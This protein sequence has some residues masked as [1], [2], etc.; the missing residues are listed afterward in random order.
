MVYDCVIIGGGI[1]GLQCAIQLGRYMYKVL[2][3]DSGD[4]RSTLCRSYHNVL[5]YPSGVSGE[6]LRSIGE[7]QAK[8]Y[9]VEFLLEKVEKV[10]KK[11]EVFHVTTHHGDE[12]RAKRLLLATGV[13]DRIPPI[14][15]LYP[16]LG[17]SVYICPDCDG[18]EIKDQE[19]IV[20]GSGNVGAN[21]ALTLL[22]W[23][24]KLVY[25]NHERKEVDETLLKRLKKENIEYY[26]ESIEQVQAKDG[27]FQGVQLADGTQLVSNHGFVAFGNNEVRSELAAQLGV[28]RMENK[29]ILVDPRSKMTNIKHVWAAGD[30]VAHSEQVTV[31]MGDGLQAAIFIHKSLMNE[32]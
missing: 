25:V 1:A 21:A 11:N 2:V 15:E 29:H 17:Q 5:G 30:V 27:Q 12:K 9:G 19:C 32:S 20:I 22:F 6:Y 3:I 26:E 31:A 10:E 8:Q 23:S 24:K 4:G 28:E 7:E 16:C 18:Y 13:M 14:P